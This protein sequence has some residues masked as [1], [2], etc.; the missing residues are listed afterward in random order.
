MGEVKPV[1]NSITKNTKV[2]LILSSCVELKYGCFKYSNT[3]LKKVPTI[4]AEECFYY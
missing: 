4:K 2:W 3:V 1:F